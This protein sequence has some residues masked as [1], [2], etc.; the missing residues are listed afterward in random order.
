MVKLGTVLCLVIIAGAAVESLARVPRGVQN[1][2]LRMDISTFGSSCADWQAKARTG[3]RRTAA[4]LYGAP[5]RG[6]KATCRTWRPADLDDGNMLISVRV[7]RR[8]TFGVMYAL[9][10]RLDR[11]IASGK[12]RTTL[13]SFGVTTYMPIDDE[14]SCVENFQPCR[15][16]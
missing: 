7:T 13:R 10:D 6:V 11:D 15:F 16:G 12:F 3:Y 4:K 14:L 9:E 2:T 5:L 1:F 8:T